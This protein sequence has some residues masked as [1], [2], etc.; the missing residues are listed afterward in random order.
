MSEKG[1]FIDDIRKGV[2]WINL[3]QN[4]DKWRAVVSTVMNPVV[5]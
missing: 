2:Y 1:K 3:A 5:P 4:R